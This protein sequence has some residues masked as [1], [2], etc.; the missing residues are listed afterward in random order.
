MERFPDGARVCFVG[1]SITHRGLY[2]A[3]IASHYRK[4]YPDSKVEFYDCG[5]S[6][7]NLGNAIKIY[8][9]D[10]AIY[11]PTHIV[12]MIG[13]NDSKRNLLNDDPRSAKRYE[14]L[15]EA[16]ENYGKNENEP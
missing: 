15:N 6:G 14:A 16:Y 1:D 2:I 5:I 8:N 13:I 11:D 9:E 7:G 4:Y 3:H 12:L 10:T